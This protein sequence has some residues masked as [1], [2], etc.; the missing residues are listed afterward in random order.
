M[1]EQLEN[2][3]RLAER[4]KKTA[5]EDESHCY[6]DYSLHFLNLIEIA[7]DEYNKE[8]GNGKATNTR[9]KE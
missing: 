9:K 4:L 3:R 6:V 7:T 1:E 5:E 8:K 2:L